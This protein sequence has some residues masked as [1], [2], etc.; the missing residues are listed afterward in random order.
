[1]LRRASVLQPCRHSPLP[2]QRLELRTMAR[3][4]RP[5]RSAAVRMSPPLR[6]SSSS[7][8][9]A[10]SR[11]RSMASNAAL[12]PRSSTSSP[13]PCCRVQSAR[14]SSGKRQMMPL[15]M[16]VL[17]PTATPCSSGM[18]AASR[19]ACEPASRMASAMAP[20]MSRGRS[21]VFSQ[22]PSSSMT[23]EWPAALSTRAAVAP[24]APVP[25]TTKSATSSIRYLAIT[26]PPG[27]RAARRGAGGCLRARSRSRRAWRGS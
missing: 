17:P 22:P 13:R 10:T 18:G 26:H 21:G 24:P 5:R 27:P 16:A 11:S 3:P 19:V 2:W 1:M 23:T 12:R 6:P 25:T 4:G 8:V 20:T 15:L 14:T 9:S 7:E